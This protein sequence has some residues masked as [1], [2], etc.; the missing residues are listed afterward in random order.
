MAAVGKETKRK[1]AKEMVHFREKRE[2]AGLKQMEA[3]KALCAAGGRFD[4]PLLSKIE[5]GR[6]LPMPPD[7]QV[8]CEVYGVGMLELADAEDITFALVR[9]KKEGYAT[10]EKRY[11]KLTVRL[12]LELAS[13]LI[14]ALRV[15]GLEGMTAWVT[16]YARRTVKRAQKKSAACVRAQTTRAKKK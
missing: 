15:L 5:N 13:A 6:C 7:A 9:P 1:G 11:Y 14:E 16:R 2:A 10:K 4:Q 3:V 8:M 12:D